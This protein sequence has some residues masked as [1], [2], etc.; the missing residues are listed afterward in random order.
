[1]GL[2]KDRHKPLPSLPRPTLACI[3]KPLRFNLTLA[4]LPRNPPTTPPDFS[5]P[6]LVA[7]FESLGYEWR[8]T[9]YSVL[10]EAIRAENAD[11]V[12]F[13]IRTFGDAC[14]SDLVVDNS[15]E[16]YAMRRVIIDHKEQLLRALLDAGFS[17]PPPPPGGSR[18][19]HTPLEEASASG[20]PAG[21]S[22]GAS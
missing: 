9:F 11:L 20:W 16:C 21:I 15:L 22:D 1:M 2:A 6:D 8:L 10:E 14:K 17:L 4:P 5:A 18:G 19:K 3:S 13:L 12:V 7:Q